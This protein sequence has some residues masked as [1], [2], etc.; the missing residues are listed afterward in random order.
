MNESIAPSNTAEASDQY[1]LAKILGIWAAAALPMAILSWFI[2]PLLAPDFETDPLGS[3]VSRVVLLTLGEIWLF[4]LS[5]IIVRQ[6]EGNLKWATVKQRLRLNPPL[7]PKTG[8]KRLRLWLW[9]I[10]A[11]IGIALTDAVLA[12]RIDNIWVSI[13][14]FLAEPPGFSFDAIFESPE[15]ME[16]LVGAWWFLALF[17]VF[18]LFNTI[19]GE[20]FLFRGVLL[21]KM[22]GVF[23]NWSWVA[24]G[25]LFGFFHLHQ[26]W[27]ILGTII[28]GTLFFALPA[29][30]FRS[31]WMS[32]IVHSAQSVLFAFLILGVVLGLA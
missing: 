14:P 6:E 31:T 21:P 13:F 5:M 20:E 1:S 25:I 15:M 28:G 12:S 4:L 2:F 23:G 24:N 29:W 19:L 18:A 16:K 3:S 26:P 22:D 8:Q 10:P 32:V 17:L 7:D 11:L 30:R 9:I 27:G